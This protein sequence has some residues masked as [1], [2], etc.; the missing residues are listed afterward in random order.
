MRAFIG[1]NVL[2]TGTYTPGNQ[3]VH[4][5]LKY[6]WDLFSILFSNIH[7]YPLLGRK[8]VIWQEH[9]FW[10]DAQL[11]WL[12]GHVWLSGCHWI[13]GISLRFTRVLIYQV[14]SM[15]MCGHQSFAE[16][17]IYTRGFSGHSFFKLFQMFS[18]LAA[19]C[20]IKLCISLECPDLGDVMSFI[21]QV[22]VGI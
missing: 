16:L 7:V 5:I 19:Y 21:E 14:S 9:M 17:V 6:S 20:F 8:L 3:G 15:H 13:S 1:C 10:F 18:I 12:Q 4:V 11:S 22:V 2:K